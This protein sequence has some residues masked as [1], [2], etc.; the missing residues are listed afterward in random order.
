MRSGGPIYP[1]GVCRKPRPDQP[2]SSAR[3]PQLEALKSGIVDVATGQMSNPKLIRRLSFELLYVE[4]LV[5]AVRSG[6][7]L[8]AEPNPST[9]AALEHPGNAVYHE[10]NRMGTF[11]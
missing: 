6:H 8:L 2:H 10:T 3:R 5:F 9:V 7:P 4:P 1:A 11:I